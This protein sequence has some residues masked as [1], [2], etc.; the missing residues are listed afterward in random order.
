MRMRLINLLLVSLAVGVLAG[1][2]YIL[3]SRVN[4]DANEAL[5]SSISAEA[6]AATADSNLRP[7]LFAANAYFVDHSTYA[8]M[9]ADVLRSTYDSGLAPGLEVASAT[10]AGFCV[11]IEVDGRSFSYLDR[12]GTV[13]P[14][15]G[16]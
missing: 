2:A 12:S 3:G 8:G 5:T 10:S 9:T 1:G 6:A 14:G 15:D 4:D 13:A 16:C 7:A 11:E